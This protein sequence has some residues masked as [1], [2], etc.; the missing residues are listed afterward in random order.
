MITVALV[1]AREGL[2]LGS[3]LL[4]YLLAVVVIAAVGGLVP[5]LLAAGLTFALANWFLTPPFHTLEVAER[6]SVVELVVFVV[7]AAIVSATVELAARDRVASQARL[8]TEAARSREL[9]E[10]NRVRSAL[11]AA[12]GHDLRTPLAGVKAAVSTL[13]QDD[14]EWRPDQRADLLAMIEEST[15]R[16]THVISNLLDLSRLRSDAF[17]VHRAPVGLDD[18]VSRALLAERTSV[19]THIPDDLPLVDVDAGLLERVVENLV[20]NA[21]R[22]SPAR[23]D[24][25]AVVTA[26]DGREPRVCLQVI[27]HGPGVAAE[28]RASLFVPFQR[29]DDR[30]P[31]SHAGL[32]LA[33]AQGFTEA[34]GARITPSTTPGGGLTMSVDLP[35]AAR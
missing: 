7:A 14:V 30:E 12:V 32:G 6:D 5:G 21:V 16:L 20:E 13:R 29:L 18:V 3:L 31:G 8:A 28:R 10:A 24:L 9:A 19:R 35:V 25:R 15:D 34:M 26:D 1:A 22:F 2:E 17:T 4:L 33:I 27:D 23:V 11:I